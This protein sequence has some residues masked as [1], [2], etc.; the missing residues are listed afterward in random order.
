MS[1]AISTSYQPFRQTQKLRTEI[2]E[3]F[4]RPAQNLCA[5]M[6]KVIKLFALV[7]FTCIV[8]VLEAIIALPVLA[9]RTCTLQQNQAPQRQPAALQYQFP[10]FDHL[11]DNIEGQARVNIGNSA[12][13]G[14]NP[15][16][17]GFGED[18]KFVACGI[19]RAFSTISPE[20]RQLYEQQ[21]VHPEQPGEIDPYLWTTAC[22]IV[23]YLCC[24]YYAVPELRESL[25]CPGF[26]AP[27][28]QQSVNGAKSLKD[29]SSR[30][31]RLVPP[32][33][34]Y[35][36]FHTDVSLAI[37]GYNNQAAIMMKIREPYTNWQMDTG[38]RLL[39][40]EI[41]KLAHLVSSTL[42]FRNEV[43]P[44]AVARYPNEHI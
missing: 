12:K 8:F 44:Q 1:Q 14:G 38:A 6:K 28:L 16:P 32:Q 43:Y 31:D 22:S 5:T 15:H 20:K 24:L 40:K 29:L 7:L 35:L 19:V 11:V 9:F 13:I 17:F 23:H 21:L 33:R 3:T 26:L 37:R 39:V 18:P 4:D 41:L 34:G 10:N 2:S 42:R 25:L 30:F 27:Y 36:T